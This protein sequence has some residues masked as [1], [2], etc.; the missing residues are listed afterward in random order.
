MGFQDDIQKVSEL[1]LP[2]EKLYRSNIL[3]L[4]ATGLIGSC[5]VNTLLAKRN[6]DYQIFACGRDTTRAHSLFRKYREDSRFHFIQ[7]DVIK[8]L[9]SSLDFHFIIH[10]ASDACPKSFVSVPVEVMKSNIYG[11]ANILDYGKDHNLKRFMYISSGEMYGQGD[12]RPFTEEYSGYVDHTSPRAC[13]P[14]SKRA[15]EVLSLSYAAEYGIDITIARPCH[16]YG[17]CFS[18]KDNRVYAQFFRNLLHGED[19][20]LK[21]AGNQLRS[22]CYV[23]DCVSAIFHILLK[24]TSGEAYNI[25][26]ENSKIT[27]RELAEKIAALENKFVV[28]REPASEEK[29][30]F[31]TVTESVLDT[32]KIRSLGWTIEGTI[33]MK[34]K[35]TYLE[36][37]SQRNNGNDSPK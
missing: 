2:W 32:T 24:G 30:G 20:V 34:L 17:P 31:N 35:N 23:A 25:A 8:P 16:V 3:V 1:S 4:G 11:V 5:I 15:A 12:G 26:D 37:L 18:E 7:H 14:A 33:D 21:S 36:L 19:I 10:A 28:L 22:W 13:Y 6:A 9:E 27:I 29:K